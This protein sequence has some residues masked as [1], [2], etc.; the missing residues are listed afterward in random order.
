MICH[1][2]AGCTTC[3]SCGKSHRRN[4]CP[5]WHLI[6]F[7]CCKQGHTQRVCR[8]L[9][10]QNN[11]QEVRQ[12]IQQ[13]PTGKTNRKTLDRRR[14]ST[15]SVQPKVEALAFSTPI[16]KNLLK[17]SV[18][19]IQTSALL[20]SGATISCVSLAFM[21]KL[22]P[23]VMPPYD[24]PE[25]PFMFGVREEKYPVIGS[26][27]LK[28][29]INDHVVCQ[30]FHILNDPPTSIILGMDF[31]EDQTLIWMCHPKPSLYKKIN[32]PFPSPNHPA[33]PFCFEHA[34]K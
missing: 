5:S 24:T 16:E 32:I 30:P 2:A 9:A 34:P 3:L 26:T 11:Q 1:I 31:L 10:K 7:H 22:R 13:S 6:C 25:Y 18:C 27:V 15:L 19:N 12:S 23:R 14:K 29:F 8:Q 21:Q 33:V 4:T 17:L 20:D 28:L